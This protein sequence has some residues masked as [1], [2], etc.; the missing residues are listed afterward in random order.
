MLHMNNAELPSTVCPLGLFEIS[1][2]SLKNNKS[3]KGTLSHFI[4]VTVRNNPFTNILSVCH[5]PIGNGVD[6]D[7]GFKPPVWTLENV[8]GG[9]LPGAK[10]LFSSRTEHDM[11][12]KTS[13]SSDENTHLSHS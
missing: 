3:A 12:A 13:L 7:T 1:S 9:S 2:F 6:V 11:T 10:T 8:C 4:T 5:N